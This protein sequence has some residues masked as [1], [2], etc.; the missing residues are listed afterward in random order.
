MSE[1]NK[2]C[3][4]CIHLC[5]C[6]RHCPV[7]L[8]REDKTCEHYENRNS[9][10]ELPCAVGEHII[11]FE[12][13]FIPTGESARSGISNL[14]S[15]I[16]DLEWILANRHRFGKTVFSGPDAFEKIKLAFEEAQKHE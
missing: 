4:Q 9:Y 11:E 5:V 10:I 15:F 3:H 8:Y 2:R 13:D 7:E 6:L 12:N 1:R 14:H 16:P